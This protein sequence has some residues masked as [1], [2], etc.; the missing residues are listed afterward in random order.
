MR[1]QISSTLKGCV[2]R[3]LTRLMS[4]RNLDVHVTLSSLPDLPPSAGLSLIKKNA[5]S[6]GSQF[7]R[8]LA[9]T[10]V[11]LVLCSTYKQEEYLKKCMVL[12]QDSI[13][14]FIL[15]KYGVSVLWKCWQYHETGKFYI[16]F[17]KLVSFCWQLSIVVLHY[18]S[19]FCLYLL[20][21]QQ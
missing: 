6:F 14:G 21:I 11:A 12:K 10:N 17:L 8:L 9:L 18:L 5:S 20:L 16:I 13:W 19:E 1:N 4:Q 15:S 3:I 2:M 7:I